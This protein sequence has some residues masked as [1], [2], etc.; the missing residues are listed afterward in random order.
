MT[1]GRVVVAGSIN[2]DI[3]AKASRIPRPGETVLGTA[4][5]Y[6]PGGK[7]AN[8][9]VASRRAGASVAMI[10]RVGED[11]F[12]EVLT[13]NLAA[14][15]VDVDHVSKGTGASGVAL[16]VVDEAGENSI[17]VTPGANA[18]VSIDTSPDAL[19]DADVAVAQLEI[20][21]PTVA[22]FLRRCRARGMRTVLNTA[23]A[24]PDAQACFDLVDVLIL[25]ETELNAYV[26]TD[27]SD[28]SA[29]AEAARSLQRSGDQ[30]IVVTLGARGA[31]AVYGESLIE[32]PGLTVDA[33]DTTGAGDCFVGWVAAGL[34]RGRSLEAALSDANRAA[35][36]CV[37]SPGAAPSMPSAPLVTRHLNSLNSDASHGV[38]G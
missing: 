37:Q 30:A 19:P 20:P 9:A 17:V 8:Q 3:V 38:A 31:F 35:S 5:N 14:E 32:A 6:Y 34:A 16:I 29:M 10:G 24:V 33:V 36:L 12:G 2:M 22:D 27:T 25:N 7:G 21:V 11:A 1:A 23:P 28:V 26:Q 4:L 13:S 15:G 18:H